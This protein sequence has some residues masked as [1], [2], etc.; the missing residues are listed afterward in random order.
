MIKVVEGGSSCMYIIH[1]SLALNILLLGLLSYCYTMLNV[2]LYQSFNLSL[3]GY[4]LLMSAP[5]MSFE[6]TMLSTVG[7]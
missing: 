1:M 3:K 4:L 5:K 2:M 6:E 7:G